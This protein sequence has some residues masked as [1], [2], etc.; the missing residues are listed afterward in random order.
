MITS[1]SVCSKCHI[2]KPIDSFYRSAA[3]K[4]HTAECKICSHNR[5]NAYRALHK[6]DI[7][8]W[9]RIYSKN[10]RDPESTRRWMNKNKDKFKSYQA[11]WRKDNI[12]KVRLSYT[13][14][15]HRRRKLSWFRMSRSISEGIRIALRGRK[16]NRPWEHIVGYTTSDIKEH[17]ERLFTPGMSWDNYGEWHIDHVIPISK[18]KIVSTERE[19]FKRCWAL[20]NLQPLWATTREIDG[21]KYIGNLNKSDK[22]IGSNINVQ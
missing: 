9:Q 2:E 8:E 4:G 15:N 7:N 17:L 22:L 10:H 20:T 12:E 1:T 21:V 18:F 13:K 16:R 19:D 14:Q 5:H 6:K 3:K 11:R